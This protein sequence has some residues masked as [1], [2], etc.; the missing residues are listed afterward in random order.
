M[1]S[2]HFLGAHQRVLAPVIMS[3]A[4][5][6][7]IGLASP[8]AV[9]ASRTSHWSG[10]AAVPKASSGLA[11]SQTTSGKW[12]Y[13]AYTTSAGGIDYVIHN[14]TWWPKVR[15][16]SGK[17]VA[18]ATKL[19]PAITVF[20]GHLWVF[21]VNGSGQLRYTH[22]SG[23][24]WAAAET[25][26]PSS[27]GTPL[28]SKTPALAVSQS[29]LWVVYKGHSTTN[30]YYTSTTGSTWSAQQKAVSGAT[31]NAPTVAPTGLSAAPLAIAWTESSG[32]IGYG[33]LGFLGFE[34]IG[35]VPSAGTNAAPS[36]DFMTA[37]KGETMYLAWKGTHT[38]KVFYSDVTDFAASTFSPSSWGP[39]ATL[40]TALTLTRPT[41]ANSG[42]TLY[43]V[44]KSN[45]S[46]NL[47]YESATAPTS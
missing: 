42:T 35:S 17:D 3:A 4:V 37:T 25:V 22:L 45:N 7:A 39:Q 40:P 24:T 16:V 20:G 9:A 21:W 36:L 5:L 15:T 1:S 38:N 44:Y 30:I 47:N 10:Q 31:S 19:A 34:T 8:A 23:T 2:I 26:N 27:G 46:D 13:V 41:L 11:P 14:G 43:A 6:T 18:P 33:I 12:W 28:T 29:T 32:K